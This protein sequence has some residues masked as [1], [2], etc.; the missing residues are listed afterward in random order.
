MSSSL[1]RG[2]RL[3]LRLLAALA[4]SLL[5]LWLFLYLFKAEGPQTWL[6]VHSG[7]NALLLCLRAGREAKGSQ[8]RPTTRRMHVIDLILSLLLALS[9][10]S[11]ALIV[12]VQLNITRQSLALAW[13]ELARNGQ[14]FGYFSFFA[15]QIWALFLLPVPWFVGRRAH[16]AALGHGASAAILASGIILSDGRLLAAAIIP[17]LITWLVLAQSPLEGDRHLRSLPGRLLA[18]AP[19]LG[20]ALAL[21]LLWQLLAPHIRQTARQSRRP[22]FSLLIQSLAPH[23]PLLGD[24]PGYGFSISSIHMPQRVFL[25]DRVIFDVNGPPFAALY[26]AEG[27]FSIWNGA[28]WERGIQAD[29]L[30]P[31]RRLLP[32]DSIP[33]SAIRLVL[34]EDLLETAPM[35][36]D[37]ALVILKGDYRGAMEASSLRGIRFDAGARRG[38]SIIQLPKGAADYGAAAYGADGYGA[39]GYGAAAYGADG[40]SADGYSAAT[41]GQSDTTALPGSTGPSGSFIPEEVRSLSRSLRRETDGDEAFLRALLAHFMEDFTYSLS[42]PEAPKGVDPLDFFLS[43]SRTGFCVWFAAAFVLACQDAGLEARMAEGYRI[44]LDQA[45][46]GRIRGYHAHAWPEVR[47]GTEWLRF[48]PTP[49]FAGEDPFARLARDRNTRDQLRSLFPDSD[50]SFISTGRLPAFF[51]SALPWIPAA[52]ALLVLGAAGLLRLFEGEERRDRRHGRRMTARY[53]R[54]GI[55]PPE[56]GGWL[57]WEDAVRK[58]DWKG[59]AQKDCALSKR[60]RE[61]FYAH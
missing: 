32:D 13:L 37:T 1:E 58:L 18:V 38:L 36:P 56:T 29:E 6:L 5:P 61:R 31:I 8:S 48:E 26:L 55:P 50:K 45:G 28:A 41:T 54:R 22:D 39:D 15:T 25:S 53:R 7:V 47:F 12:L 24:M 40:Y 3:A 30:T 60:I 43:D 59:R 20:L 46:Q 11:M 21:A 4:A 23:F 16:L 27:R 2:I 17:A 9:V 10:G 51:T 19:A 57:A 33:P 49:P 42:T 44:L 52:I 35:A 34:R 14:A